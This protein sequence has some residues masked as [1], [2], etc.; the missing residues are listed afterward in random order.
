MNAPTHRYTVE[1]LLHSAMMHQGKGVDG[2]VGMLR[3]AAADAERLESLEAENA[4]LRKAVESIEGHMS[5][6]PVIAF[7][8]KA[9][10]RIARNALKEG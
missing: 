8:I 4:R 10:L 2:L 3:Q 5:N 7:D 6:D 1:Q 9:C